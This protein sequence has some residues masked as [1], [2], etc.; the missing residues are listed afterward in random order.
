[1]TA[2]WKKRCLGPQQNRK[3][4][5]PN[6]TKISLEH[7]WWER[8]TSSWSTRETEYL[9][10]LAKVLRSASFG[11]S[12]ARSQANSGK[13]INSA[14]DFCRPLVC[15]SLLRRRS[16]PWNGTRTLQ[17]LFQILHIVETMARGKLMSLFPL[18]CL[19]SAVTPPSQ[20]S[21]LALWRMRM[22]VSSFSS[23]VPGLL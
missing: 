4:L 1:M 19:E 7:I 3:D 21:R 8:T 15:I 10:A 18:M 22:K 9:L 5:L 13:T 2:P 12:Q 23:L 17:D 20:G 16:L 11:S 14:G 6:P